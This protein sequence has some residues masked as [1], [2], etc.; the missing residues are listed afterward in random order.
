MNSIHAIKVDLSAA[1]HLT[2]ISLP[3]SLY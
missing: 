1:N 2:L 3:T